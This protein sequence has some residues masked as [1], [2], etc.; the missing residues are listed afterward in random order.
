MVQSYLNSEI[1]YKKHERFDKSDLNHE[2]IPYDFS[3]NDNDIEIAL[4]KLHESK[5]DNNILFINV[6]KIEDETVKEHIGIFELYKTDKENIYDE[7]NDIDID[8]LNEILLFNNNDKENN[9]I[10]E[11]DKVDSDEE[12]KSDEEKSNEE[13]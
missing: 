7:D 3:I 1:H 2:T 4:G 13:K 6:Y 11:T 12:D 5:I 8:K 9:V 10:D